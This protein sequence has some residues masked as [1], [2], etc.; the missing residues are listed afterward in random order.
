MTQTTP[1]RPPD[2]MVFL[3]LCYGVTIALLAPVQ[4][5]RHMIADETVLDLVRRSIRIER[6]LELERE[7]KAGLAPELVE[8]QRPS[9]S[10][11]ESKIREERDQLLKDTRTEARYQSLAGFAV[12]AGMGLV[13][14]GI[15]QRRRGSYLPPDHCPSVIELWQ[16]RQRKG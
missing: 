16:E 4:I 13:A 1:T 2:Y 9:D 12:M 5:G 15:W 10:E 6:T 14:L 3:A 7:V 11:I 8:L